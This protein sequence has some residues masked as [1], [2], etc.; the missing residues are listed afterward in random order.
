MNYRTITLGLLT[1]ITPLL[2][3]TQEY[4]TSAEC[5]CTAINDANN[6]CQP[7]LILTEQAEKLMQALDE[8]HRCMLEHPD[9]SKLFGTLQKLI[10]LMQQRD[11]F[12][13]GKP[14][15]PGA[16]NL[17]V[18]HGARGLGKYLTIFGGY[19]DAASAKIVSSILTNLQHALAHA[20]RYIKT[21]SDVDKALVGLHLGNIVQELAQL[22]DIEAS[23]KPHLEIMQQL[24]RTI[25]LMIEELRQGIEDNP[26]KPVVTTQILTAPCAQFLTPEALKLA[27][28]LYAYGQN[29]LVDAFQAMDDSTSDYQACAFALEVLPTIAYQL[30]SYLTHA[31]GEIVVQLLQDIHNIS[32]QV[33]LCIAHD[34][35]QAK[36][37]AFANCGKLIQDAAMHFQLPTLPAA[38]LTILKA[39]NLELPVIVKQFNNGVARAKR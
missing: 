23:G 6:Q 38:F 12:A 14:L 29:E 7:P 22:I 4:A 18:K 25:P 26:I 19:L 36:Q 15:K 33:E 16:I 31:Q 32:L 11:G 20:E 28:I 17:L 37:L 1:V 21:K 3:G 9:H 27:N 10:K 39:C 13:T 8:A 24:N 30:G 2:H 5:C 34:D 35:L